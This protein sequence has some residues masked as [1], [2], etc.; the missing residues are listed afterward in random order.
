MGS[1]KQLSFAFGEISPELHYNAEGNFFRQ[2]LKK[3]YN[4]I[5]RASAGVSNRTGSVMSKINT[6]DITPG[7]EGR[8]FVFH[9]PVLD[10]QMCLVV[11]SQIPPTSGPGYFDMPF[12][13]YYW[14]T[15]FGTTTAYDSTLSPSGNSTVG[16]K[17]NLDTLEFRQIKNDLICT[18][19][20]IDEP[21]RA[22]GAYKY[23]MINIVLNSAGTAFYRSMY[24]SK[25]AL[26]GTP[27]AGPFTITTYFLTSGYDPMPVSYK[28]YQEKFDGSELLWTA[29]NSTEG[30]PNTSATNQVTGLTFPDPTGDVKQYNVYRSAGTIIGGVPTSGNAYALV[31][32]IPAGVGSTSFADALITADL[33]A[34]PPDDTTIKAV[35]ELGQM[36]KIY[37]SKERYFV[38]PNQ[39]NFQ[40]NLYLSKL[41]SN[42]FFDRGLAPTRLDSFSMVTRSNRERASTKGIKAV[43]S[44]DSSLAFSD[45]CVF[46]L[47]GSDGGVLSYDTAN[48]VIIV[49]EGIADNCP[50]VGAG[51]QIFFINDDRTTMISIRKSSTSDTNF[52]PYNI[53]TNSNHLFSRRSIKKIQVVN[54]KETIVWALTNTGELISCTDVATGVGG[55]GRHKITDGFIEDIAVVKVSADRSGSYG[56]TLTETEVL[57]LFVNRDGTRYVEYMAPR[58]DEAVG[59]FAYADASVYA[60]GELQSFQVTLKITAADYTAGNILTITDVDGTGFFALVVPL[61]IDVKKTD[62]TYLRLFKTAGINANS[63]NCRA[64]YDIPANLQNSNILKENYELPINSVS[65]LQ[66]L[67][68]KEVS[69]IGDGTVLSSPLNLANQ[70]TTMSV[71]ALGILDLGDYYR[72]VYVGLPYKFTMETLPLEASDNRTFTDKGKLINMVGVALANTIGGLLT[73]RPDVELTINNTA[74]LASPRNS[75]MVNNM[76]P[77]SGMKNENFPAEWD[78]SGSLCVHQV[79]PLPITVAAIY[80]K[81]VIGG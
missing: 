66:H 76:E 79:D 59:N 1:G 25:E 61:V 65:N 31:A 30:M 15:G 17:I 20:F 23:F 5:V 53:G 64:D 41:G 68:G 19:E 22:F 74:N 7:G 3:L 8:F 36:R 16:A 69:V 39:E 73:Q 4:G 34:T 58:D 11:K 35:T 9:H 67:A 38:L 56:S 28:I 18:F 78:D 13:L 42:F 10:K 40:E 54:A 71:D 32:R 12:E 37:F 77:F 80:P 48:P 62:G 60:G 70:L 52:E 50:P 44:M 6:G 21:G 63:M 29:F 43:A 81:G 2:G 72:K 45:D 14:D 49:N 51:D 33:S 55:F 47:K 46:E 57:A 24:I 75:D 27:P 26:S